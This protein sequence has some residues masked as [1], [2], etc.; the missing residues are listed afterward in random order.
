MLGN[1]RGTDAVD[2]EDPRHCGSVDLAE[3]FLGGYGIRGVQQTGRD[4]QQIEIAVLRYDI[5]SCENTVLVEDIDRQLRYDIIKGCH[6]AAARG[7]YM[8]KPAGGAERVDKGPADSAAASDNQGALAFQTFLQ[9]S[10]DDEPE[11]RT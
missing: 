8:A 3:A 10:S 4:D 1:Q 2:R 11:G 5:R 7:V 6:G 9:R